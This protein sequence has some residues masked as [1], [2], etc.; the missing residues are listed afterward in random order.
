MHPFCWTGG[1]KINLHNGE[2]VTRIET[3]NHL[4]YKI[5]FKVILAN[6]TCFDWSLKPISIPNT[7][8]RITNK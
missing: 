7:N 3:E 4:K 1:K 2:N 8:V 6:L 5:S